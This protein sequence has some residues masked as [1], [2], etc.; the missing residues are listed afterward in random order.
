MSY[1]D[2]LF[3]EMNKHP[4]PSNKYLYH[5]FRNRVVFEQRRGKKSYFQ[6]YSEKHKT[7]MKMLWHGIRSTVNTSNKN[8]ASHICQ[9][10]VNGKLISDPVK[11]RNIFN[12]YFVNV[13]CNIDKS[14]PR[15]K[16]SA[17]DYLKKQNP[18]SLFL[19]PVTPQEIETII[20]SFDKNK[21]VGP[22]SIPIF[23]LKTLSSY[24]SKP[25]SSIINNQSFETGIFPQNLNLE[26]SIPFIKKELLIYLQ[27]IDPS[28]YYLVLQKLFKN[29]MYERLYKFLD[30]FEILYTLQF[31]FRES[32]STSH[33]LLSLTKTIKESIDNGK[34]GCSIFL[35]LQKA[36]DT[37]NHKIFLQ[38][39]EHYGITGKVLGWFRSYLSGRSQYV[40][41]NG[42]S[43]EILPVTCGVPQGSLLGPL[44]F[45][46]Y[47]NDLPYVSKILKFYLFADDT[48]I[49]Y[50]S[51]NLITLQKTV[52]RE[53]RKVRKWLEENRLSLNIGKTNH[54]IFHSHAKR[55]DE[56]I[57][58]KL[59]RKPIKRVHHIKYLG[60]LVDSTLSWKPHVTELSEKLAKSVGIFFKI[61]HYVTLETLKLL[62]YS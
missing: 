54:V 61:R 36:F 33:T 30:S 49:Y 60:V 53:L 9:L 23:L 40:V 46:I 47:V 56:F 39:L 4:T 57:Q 50:D 21:S 2:K 29:M 31:G 55:I 8:Q 43:S 32:H 15:T 44:L 24:I 13:C 59:G 17:L 22:Y 35:D 28:P 48:S 19:A 42:H 16:K 5:K 41:V 37:V 38:E 62:Y 7:N 12:K 45:L 6:E 18:N 1:R 52:N 58:I 11:M 27:I 3:N 20:Q 14:I 10:N 26:K 25:L 51:E 34:F